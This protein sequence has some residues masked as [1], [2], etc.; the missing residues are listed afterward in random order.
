MSPPLRYSTRPLPRYR[1]LRGHHPHPTGD[2]RGHSFGRPDDF[3]PLANEDW[4]NN[5]QYLFAID[6]FNDGYWWEAHE[7]LEP[8]WRAAGRKTPDGLFLQG[9]I[10]VSGAMLKEAMGSPEPARRMAKAG[11]E[12]LLRFPG[13]SL[14]IDAP[15]LVAAID[16]YLFSEA[17][18]LPTIQ[19]AESAGEVQ[20]SPTEAETG[21]N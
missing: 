17:N 12:K 4:R 1:Y 19:L 21:E 20:R 8:L 16:R 9:L 5:E 7:A 2:S 15:K 11:F 18:D 10:Q 13:V 3:Q 14:G 6:L